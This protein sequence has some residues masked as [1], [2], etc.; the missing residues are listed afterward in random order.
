MAKHPVLQFA[1][2]RAD[3]V[4]VEVTRL[5]GRNLDFDQAPHAHAFFELLYIT[6]GSGWHRIGLTHAAVAAGDVLLIAPGE[7]HD[8][9]GLIDV[10]G[11]LVLFEASALESS[12]RRWVDLPGELAFLP[13]IRGGR[14]PASFRVPAEDQLE[15]ER[16][17]AS[18]S[19][20]LESSALG[21]NIVVRAE[22]QILLIA[23]ARLV[24][25]A[26]GLRGA[27]R[28][29][30]AE[31]FQFI[32]ARYHRPISLVDVAKAVGRS[33]AHLTTVVRTETGRSVLRWITERRMAEARRLLEQTDLEVAEIGERVGFP[34][35]SY[36]VRRFHALHRV[37]PMVFRRATHQPKE[38]TI[39][40]K[41]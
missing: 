36:F 29:M 4:P 39:G 10:T 7:V 30:L 11:Y 13:F 23:A 31:V 38:S 25:P 20:E 12:Q 14:A 35:P 26:V 24:G 41:V 2:E 28:P 9:R 40:S 16:K 6:G 5:H 32:D 34:E 27:H 21:R 33:P 8:A 37:T 19:R 1:S 18:L 17:C 3:A 15:W 22:L